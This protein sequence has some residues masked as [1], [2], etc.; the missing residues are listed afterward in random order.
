MESFRLTRPDPLDAE[1]DDEI[2]SLG[3][4]NSRLP[5][6]PGAFGRLFLRAVACCHSVV[7]EVDEDTGGMGGGVIW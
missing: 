4:V 5:S 7:T 6:A 1:T 3:L 2:E